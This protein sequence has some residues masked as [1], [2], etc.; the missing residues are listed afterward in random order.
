MKLMGYRY[1][2]HNTKERLS[3][4]DTKKLTPILQDKEQR[5]SVLN[6]VKGIASGQVSI[7][8]IQVVVGLEK[9]GKQTE[10]AELQ[11][12]TWQGFR[13]ATAATYGD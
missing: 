2:S 12:E 9:V 8:H 13:S 4:L 10:F 6:A 5:K 11:Q 7:S 3:K 1:N